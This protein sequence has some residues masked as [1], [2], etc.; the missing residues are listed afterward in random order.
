MA[1]KPPGPSF[2]QRS[3]PQSGER[4]TLIDS[5]DGRNGLLTIDQDAE[6][7]LFDPAPGPLG[8]ENA[9]G[10]SAEDGT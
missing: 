4:P 3:F 1:I 6:L 5:R 2:G 7:L 8:R 10:K 9:V